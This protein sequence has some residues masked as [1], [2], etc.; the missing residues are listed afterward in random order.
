MYYERMYLEAMLNLFDCTCMSPMDVIL[1]IRQLTV[2]PLKDV[3]IPLLRD[4]QSKIG[5]V[6]PFDPADLDNTDD[7]TAMMLDGDKKLFIAPR[8]IAEA[9]KLARECMDYF[10][11]LC[12]KR[13]RADM[14]PRSL[15]EALAQLIGYPVKDV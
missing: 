3:P 6:I 12:I 11:A 9:L 15:T 7:Y 4:E 10:L 5:P 8:R 13:L 2:L 14:F 1:C